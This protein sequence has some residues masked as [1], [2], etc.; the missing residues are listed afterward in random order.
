MIKA[1]EQNLER[2]IQLLKNITGEEYSNKSVAPYHSSIGSHIRHV[3]DVFSCVF[4]GLYN[5][6]VD[7]SVRER[8]ECAEVKTSVGIEYFESV[9]HQLKKK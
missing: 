3:L 6:F 1:I 7:F 4:K 9:T 5:K 2:G 8:N